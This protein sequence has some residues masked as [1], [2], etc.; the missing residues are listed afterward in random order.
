MKFNCGRPLDDRIADW[1]RAKKE[2]KEKWHKW[3]AWY[4]KRLN[5]NTCIWFEYIAR[6]G[7]MDDCG[8]WKYEYE[9]I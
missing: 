1:F 6:R 4:P 3:F 7:V 8:D 5:K 9:E 2:K